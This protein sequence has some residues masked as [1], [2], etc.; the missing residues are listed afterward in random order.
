MQATGLILRVAKLFVPLSTGVTSGH[1]YYLLPCLWPREV[2]SRGRAV[3]ILPD[4]SLHA[5]PPVSLAL[6]HLPSYKL[7]LKSDLILAQLAIAGV[8]P[9]PDFRA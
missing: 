3:S 6:A 5:A 9:S 7:F 4:M 2:V 8:L 1:R